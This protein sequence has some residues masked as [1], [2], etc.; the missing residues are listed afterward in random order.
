[1]TASLSLTPL[2]SLILIH[3]TL[4][5]H[6]HTCLRI[7]I[8]SSLSLLIFLFLTHS[9]LTLCL[10]SPHVAIF[11]SIP[12]TLL[13]F[14]SY[15]TKGISAVSHH[16]ISYHITSHHIISYHITSYHITSHH[17]ISY[18]IISHHITS[19]HITSHHITSYH[20]I[21][22][23]ITSYHIISYHI[24]SYHIISYHIISHHITSH[25]IISYHIMPSRYR[26]PYLPP[27][28]THTP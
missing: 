1:M 22:Y 17:I 13:L 9:L 3:P 2:K 19:H 23:H 27:T 14:I 24:I 26:L 16:I 5:M 7:C 6:I 21:S 28:F 10:S 15:T 11:L 8:S 12:P 25:H 4:C 18:H 20:I